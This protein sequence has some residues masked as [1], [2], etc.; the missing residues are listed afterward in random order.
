MRDLLTAPLEAALNGVKLPHIKTLILPPPAH[1]LLRS[2]RAV[3]D[4]A[5]TVTVKYRAV[6]PD[7]FLISLVSNRGS[8]VERLAIPMGMWTNPSRK[9]FSTLQ[10][11]GENR[12]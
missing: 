1:P 12:D 3:E 4:V 9:R 6:D 7:A 5:C 10:G 2:C 11:Y 8:R